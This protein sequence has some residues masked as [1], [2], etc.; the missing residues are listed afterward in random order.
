MTNPGTQP[1]AELDDAQIVAKCLDGEL[2]YY[3]LLVGKYENM[4]FNLAFRI[5]KNRQDAED[6]T[7]EVFINAFN[8]LE[9]YKP[10]YKFTTWL[11]KITK[12]QALYRL[13]GLKK[14]PKATEDLE[15]LTAI[16][17]DPPQSQ[18]AD[19]EEEAQRT[20]FNSTVLEI[21]NSMPDKYRLTLMLRHLM[22]RSYQDI[23]DILDMNLG[24]VKTNIHLGRKLLREK[25]EARKMI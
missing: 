14:Q 8:H 17:R 20:E 13:R 25:L 7:Q 4:V 2:G 10:E 21:L 5:M 24:T 6:V 19:P 22:E 3:N 9:S 15:L 12:N 23:A 1:Q 16:D 11:L 18:G